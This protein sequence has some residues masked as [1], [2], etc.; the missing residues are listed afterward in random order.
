MSANVVPAQ[1]RA[2]R[3]VTEGRSPAP[4]QIQVPD[5]H[6]LLDG[7]VVAVRALDG[8]TATQPLSAGPSAPLCPQ[9]LLQ[10]L[11]RQLSAF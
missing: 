4:L 5:A 3:F 10:R 2:A 6:A 9:H 8:T 1:T 11:S 7:L